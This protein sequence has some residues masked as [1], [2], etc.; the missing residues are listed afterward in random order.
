MEDTLWYK[1]NKEKNIFVKRF[2]C[3]TL[4]FSY[5][6]VMP[7]VVQQIFRDKFCT[8]FFVTIERFLQY[9]ILWLVKKTFYIIW[10]AFKFIYARCELIDV[11]LWIFRSIYDCIKMLFIFRH[12]HWNGFYA[13]NKRML[14]Y[15]SDVNVNVLLLRKIY[16]F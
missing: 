10:I 7:S 12:I 1:T 13:L 16:V 8:V 11:N 14:K 4:T 6:K 9:D 2:F 15:N 5:T 3:I